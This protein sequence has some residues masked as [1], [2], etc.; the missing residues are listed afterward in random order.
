MKSSIEHSYLWFAR[1]QKLYGIYTLKIGRIMKRCKV[2][3]FFNSSLNFIINKY[4]SVKFL[5]AIYNTVSNS[6]NLI[7]IFYTSVLFAGDNAKYIFNSGLMVEYFTLKLY[8][9]TIFFF[10]FYER[11]L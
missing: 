8:F 9:F 3:I 6:I 10:Q 5:T 2:N 11:T 1:H 7:E 4:A